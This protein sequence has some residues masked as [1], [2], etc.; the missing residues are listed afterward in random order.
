MKFLG[1]PNNNFNCKRYLHKIEY[2]YSKK[3]YKKVHEIVTYIQNTKEKKGEY[4]SFPSEDKKTI[5]SIY[6][7]NMRVRWI[8]KKMFFLKK[9]RKIKQ[10][11]PK[12]LLTLT[13][14]PINKLAEEDKIYVYC[15]ITKTVFVFEYNNILSLFLTSLETQSYGFA[16]PQKLLN[17]Y[18]NTE[19]MLKQL[20]SIFDQLN[21][22][23]YN[24]RR[25]FPI[26]LLLFKKSGYCINTLVKNHNRYLI[27]KSCERYIQDL[28]EEEYK[29]ILD[30]VISTSLVNHTDL[31]LTCIKNIDNYRSI[32]Q[33]VL[34]QYMKDRNIYK[35]PFSYH[36]L[37]EKIIDNYGLDGP[38]DRVLHTKHRKNIKRTKR[39][40]VFR[41]NTLN[42]QQNRQ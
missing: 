18:T 22:I 25:I 35:G 37:L 2:Y 39:R 9:L 21:D 19:F 7:Q 38:H 17:P 6:Y 32:F 26:T 8:I 24:K 27:T 3:N 28:D 13:L 41:A 20:I 31:C 30:D 14:N 10:I 33:P 4:F 5:L 11:E 23:L 12:N 42:R 36:I 16:D 1:I 15:D 40:F 34:I 29:L